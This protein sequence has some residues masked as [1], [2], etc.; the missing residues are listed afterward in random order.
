MESVTPTTPKRQFGSRRLLN[1]LI[2]IVTGTLSALLY[3][4]SGGSVSF[5]HISDDQ[6]AQPSSDHD[7]E[8]HPSA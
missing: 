1:F 7:T 5:S 6:L 2:L 3:M 8:N 4:I